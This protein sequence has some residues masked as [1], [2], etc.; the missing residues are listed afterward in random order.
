MKE[1]TVRPDVK[2]YPDMTI[3]RNIYNNIGNLNIN[4]HP[5]I[6]LYNTFVQ[7][8]QPNPLLY[9]NLNNLGNL[10]SLT[11]LPNIPT[12]TS[13][14]NI[15]RIRSQQQIIPPSQL[16]NNFSKFQIL[17]EAKNSNIINNNNTHFKNKNKKISKNKKVNQPSPPVS[18]MPQKNNNRAYNNN[19]HINHHTKTNKS[20]HKT[21]ENY[22]DKNFSYSTVCEPVKRPMNH[23][24]V[25]TYQRP[26][27]SEFDK[28]VSVSYVIKDSLE[29]VK[30][31]LLDLP[32]LTG[33]C[34]Q[35]VIDQLKF[36]K[37]NFSND[38]GNV[39]TLRWKK[40]YIFSVLCYKSFSSK[41]SC[42]WSYKLIN[43]SPVSIGNL[44]VTFKLYY[45]TCQSNTLLILEF[46]FGKGLVLEIFKE[47]VVYKYLDNIFENMKKTIYN[48]KNLLEQTSSMAMDVRKQRA[49]DYFL[50]IRKRVDESFLNFH[51]INFVI[52]NPKGETIN[53]IHKGD[54]IYVIKN[55]EEMLTKFRVVD[56]LFSDELNEYIIQTI[57]SN[58]QNNLNYN[59]DKSLNT[60]FDGIFKK[61]DKFFIVNQSLTVG[62]RKIDG[63]KCFVFITHSSKDYVTDEQMKIVS[64]IKNKILIDSKTFLEKEEEKDKES[65]GGE[66]N[67]GGTSFWENKNDNSSDNNI[68]MSNFP[69][70]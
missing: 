44:D 33:C 52:Q 13:M 42:I 38:E 3:Y 70:S 16:M 37:S 31:S 2:I 29:R 14:P 21:N 7:N 50:N 5:N 26:K 11:S 30:D 58:N 19:S 8:L 23:V 1:N 51:N 66:I 54:F 53:E 39:I 41:T 36:S 63:S 46:K 47:N 43:S 22:Y 15:P 45:N 35:E 57:G 27:N 59:D 25:G 61:S 32:N 49:W 40:F 34:S 6:C 28:F 4:N 62:V 68:Y 12:L 20:N 24:L 65:G 67:F 18:K 9:S 17:K 69:F 64:T 56:V 55:N 48:N 60:D 10:N